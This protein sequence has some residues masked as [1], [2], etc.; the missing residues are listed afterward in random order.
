MTDSIGLK[1]AKL[2]GKKQC[3]PPTSTACQLINCTDICIDPLA[4][5]AKNL[6]QKFE[7]E[8][9]LNQKQEK[10]RT[11]RAT[12]D[13]TVD[14]SLNYIKNR[15]SQI[16]YA[17]SDEIDGMFRE[18]RP[19]SIKEGQEWLKSGNYRIEVPDHIN[20]EAMPPYCCSILDFFLWG[21]TAP[22]YKKQEAMKAELRKAYQTAIDEAT[23]ITDEKARLKV[24]KEFEAYKV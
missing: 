1:L 14:S 7:D 24:L 8:Y 6:Y 11:M 17:R 3:S 9:I 15:L 13:T 21:K 20:V 10:E 16:Y 2:R 22:D 23:I 5:K 12:I 4:V 18:E 19:K